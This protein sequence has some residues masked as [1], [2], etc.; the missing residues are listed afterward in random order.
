MRAAAG[1]ESPM[2]MHAALLSELDG[3]LAAGGSERQ[4]TILEKLAD[5]FV[6]GAANYSDDQIALFDNVFTRRVARIE[7]SARATFAERRAPIPRA[8]PAVSRILAADDA[9]NV[10]APIL[11]HGVRLDNALLAEFARTKS[12]QHLLA[13]SLRRYLDQS[14][15]DVLVNRGERAV[16]LSAARNLGAEFSD[17]GFTTMIARAKDDDELAACIGARQGLPRH[18]L[19]KLLAQASGAVRR[20]LEQADPRASNAIRAAVA[21]ATSYVQTMTSKVSRNYEVAEARVNALQTAGE[22]NESAVA[23]FAKERK[24]EEATVALARLCD[25]PLEAIE[26]ALVGDRPET[27]LIL[28]KAVGLT[29]ATVKAVLALRRDGQGVSPQTLETCLGT[30]SR[31]KPATARQVLAFQRKRSRQQSQVV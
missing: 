9:I 15:T 10:A 17:F 6:L 18:Y 19:L 13:I 21:D 26:T 20:I 29:W 31:M 28:G 8:P 12:Q 4:N 23:T 27:I 16:L 1:P 30:F 22:L 24:A 14:V 25:M 5:L 7:T 3:A 2:S 11:R